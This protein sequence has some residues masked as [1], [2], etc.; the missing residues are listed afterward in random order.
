MLINGGCRD[1]PT[2]LH[3][4][5]LEAHYYSY[6][7]KSFMNRVG[8]GWMS[9]TA[10]KIEDKFMVDDLPTTQTHW[11]TATEVLQ[12]SNDSLWAVDC[13]NLNCVRA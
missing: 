10:L 4:N 5:T 1:V 2:E 8:R 13:P 6:P 3:L 12:S 9:G 11:E 7:K